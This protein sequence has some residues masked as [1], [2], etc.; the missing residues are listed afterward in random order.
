MT[1]MAV[2]RWVRGRVSWH[3]YRSSWARAVQH[4]FIE[5]FN[6]RLRDECFNEHLVIFL[7]KQD[8]DFVNLGSLQ[9][10]LAPWWSRDGEPDPG[11]TPSHLRAAPLVRKTKRSGRVSRVDHDLIVL[12]ELLEKTASLLLTT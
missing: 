11:R 3:Y 1:S 9:F 2:L 8:R 12:P 7:F 5:S 4:A 10:D 6:S